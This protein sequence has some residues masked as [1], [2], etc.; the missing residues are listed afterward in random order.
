METQIIDIIFNYLFKIEARVD[1][2]AT[3]RSPFDTEDILLYTLNGIP[4]SY[5][6]FKAELFDKPSHQR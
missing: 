6:A 3:F 2:I 1:L 5:Q 4:P